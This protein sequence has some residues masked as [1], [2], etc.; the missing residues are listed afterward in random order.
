MIKKIALLAFFAPIFIP[1]A[2]AN[3]ASYTLT[4][5]AVGGTF[6][7]ATIGTI[8]SQQYWFNQACTDLG[9]SGMPPTSYLEND[10]GGTYS[11]WVE[12]AVSNPSGNVYTFTPEYDI[13]STLYFNLSP[14]QGG[15]NF[16]CG[17][18]L[19]LCDS[20]SDPAC[21]PPA[22]PAPPAANVISVPPALAP[23]MTADVSDTFATPGMVELVALAAGIP[24]F[25]VVVMYFMDYFKKMESG[26]KKR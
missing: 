19:T 18:T 12:N 26:D 11:G 13:A 3:A 21:F 20:N 25:F 10:A 23:N 1:V 24:L 16:E 15:H 9:S 7:Y 2:F 5:Q 22:P 6:V 8:P 14:V 17:A 4:G